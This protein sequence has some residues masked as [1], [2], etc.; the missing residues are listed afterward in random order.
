MSDE[1]QGW[2]ETNVDKKRPA[3]FLLVKLPRFLES[4]IFKG[5]PRYFIVETNSFPVSF[6][7]VSSVTPIEWKQETRVKF[8]R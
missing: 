8:C 1:G 6:P 5:K 4:S 7:L 3:R 2:M